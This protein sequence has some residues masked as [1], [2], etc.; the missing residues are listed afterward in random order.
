MTRKQVG[1]APIGF[2]QDT[3]TTEYVDLGRTMYAN[4]VNTTI[5]TA[6]APTV[7]DTGNL[8]VLTSGSAVTVTLPSNATQAIPVGSWIDFAATGAGAMAFAQGSSATIVSTGSVP[9]APVFRTVNSVATAIK[10]STNGWL[11]TGDI[12]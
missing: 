9:T 8:F 10:I 6:I 11:V 12:A 4:N 5:G 2:T 3:A 1:A 7:N